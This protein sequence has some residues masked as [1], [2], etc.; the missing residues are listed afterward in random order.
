MTIARADVK[1]KPKGQVGK[2]YSLII[3]MG[4]ATGPKG[5]ARYTHLQVSVFY[6]GMGAPLTVCTWPGGGQRCC[7]DGWHEPR[8]V[9]EGHSCRIESQ[10]LRGGASIIEYNGYAVVLTFAF[11]V[12]Q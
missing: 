4:L 9:L 11:I 8:R 3:E 10:G 1:P 6:F 5:K 2:D 7:Q 12:P